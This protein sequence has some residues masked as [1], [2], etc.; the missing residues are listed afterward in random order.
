MRRLA[1]VLVVSLLV[2][3][4]AAV[5]ANAATSTVSWKSKS[6][7]TVTIKK[8]S[9]VKW[10]WADSKPHDVEGRGFKSKVLSGK[11][12][13]FTHTFKKRGT[14]KIICGIHPT[15]MITTVKV[16]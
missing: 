11:G 4:L 2:I 12:K 14:F 10:V 16:K 9:K 6:I 8:N 7:K 3:A 5:A 13:T 15:T 1:P